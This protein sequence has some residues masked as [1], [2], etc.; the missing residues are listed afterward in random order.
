MSVLEKAEHIKAVEL[1]IFSGVDNYQT[2]HRRGVSQSVDSCSEKQA[3]LA[4]FPP[5]FSL[6]HGLSPHL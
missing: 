1:K 2:L 4:I 6:R 3:N 5:S